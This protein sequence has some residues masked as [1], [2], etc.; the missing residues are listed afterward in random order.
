MFVPVILRWLFSPSVRR[1]IELRHYVLRQLRSKEDLMAPDA[2]SAIRQT[3]E[4][5]RQL[6]RDRV[7]R[8]AIVAAAGR[9][10][11]T[12]AT[13]LPAPRHG[14]TRD[15]VELALV[16]AVVVLGIQTFFLE[17]MRIPSTSA[18]PTLY[19]T[20]YIDLKHDPAYR[21]FVIPGFWR[22]LVDQCLYGISYYE[23]VAQADGELTHLEPPERVFPFVTRQRLR[24]GD[25]WYSIWFPAENLMIYAGFRNDRHRAFRRP[26]FRRGESI[27]KLMVRSGDRL[28][29]DRLSYNFVRPKRGD[30]IVFIGDN[31]N[32]LEHGTFY[33]KR[34]VGLGGEQVRIGN[35][36]H[37]VINGNRLDAA[38]PGF[39]NVYTFYGR[40][41]R[42]S[43]YSGH[44][45]EAVARRYGLAPGLAPL[46][47]D[48][49]REFVVHP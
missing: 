46:F 41:P 10:G 16:A 32:E 33:I 28:L 27:L 40:P 26:S 18:Q 17:L 14:T 44:V 12:A 36:R 35:D 22:R 19:G 48:G 38:T 49:D 4:E 43:E 11:E 20:T 9:L 31:I 42:D 23:I 13:R 45:N 8:A 1:A 34:L 39:E 15:H 7:D 5:V 30:L 24:V 25:H 6:V 2:I 21:D 37:V 29:A 47:P 3:A